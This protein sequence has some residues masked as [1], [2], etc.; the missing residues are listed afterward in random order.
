MPDDPTTTYDEALRALAS[1]IPGMI[2][3]RVL[4]PDGKITIPFATGTLFRRLGLA[5]RGVADYFSAL[6]SLLHPADWK[7]LQRS[8]KQSARTLAPFTEE[9]RYVTPDGETIWLKTDS[10]P[11][12]RDD[13]CIVWNVASVDVTERKHAEEAL[14][15]NE[16]RFKDFAEAA[17]DWLW[18]QDADLRTTKVYTPER[19][20]PLLDYYRV[21]GKTRWEAADADPDNDVA[22]R[23]HR[24]D[25]LARRPFRNFRYTIT[26]PAG[27]TLYLRS[28]GNPIFDHEG[29]FAGYRGGSTDETA[30]V[31][32]RQ[33]AERAEQLATRLREAMGG[34][35]QGFVIY[36]ADDRVVSYDE[37]YR[38]MF[39]EDIPQIEAGARFIDLMRSRLKR[40][41][42]T[43]AVGREEE[44]LAE[45]LRVHRTSRGP[46]EVPYGDGRTMLVV[47]NQLSDGGVSSLLIDITALKRADQE[48]RERDER[49]RG[50]T[51]NLPGF[52]LQTFAPTD[53]EHHRVIYASSGI[54]ELCGIEAS[55][56]M[57]D[58]D[59]YLNLIHPDD[60]P[61]RDAAL[62]RAAEQM[63]PYSMDMRLN[64]LNQGVR[65]VRAVAR[66]RMI[67]GVGVVWDGVV[68]DITALKEAEAHRDYLA[69]HDQ[70]TGLPNEAHYVERLVR[71][72][73]RAE[74]DG[75]RLVVICAEL[76]SLGQVRAGSGL[77]VADDLIRQTATRL[78][79]MVFAGDTVAHVGGGRFYV[80]MNDAGQD[81]E[82]VLS[83]RHMVEAFD[84]PLMVDGTS[85]HVKIVLGVSLYPGD[86][87]KADALMRNASTALDRAK[88]SR[89][90]DYQFYSSDMTERAM[91]QQ[92][93]EGA[94][95]AAIEQRA[96]EL[97]YQPVVR[98]ADHMIVGCEALLRW[99]DA[100]R[101]MISPSDFIPLAEQ[102]GLIVPLGLSVLRAACEQIQAWRRKG[103]CRFPVNVNVSGVQLADADFAEQVLSTVAESGLVP[104][105][106]KLELTESS[107][108]RNTGVIASNIRS[109]AQAGF[110]FALDDFGVEYSTFS[111]L[112]E[113]PIDVLKIDQS[114]IRRMTVRTADALLVQ[115]II[116]MTH[117]LG[118][119]AIAEGV[120]LAAELDM[121]RDYGCDGL[122]GN[123]FSR[124]LP[125]A[126]FELAL[127]AR[128]LPPT[129]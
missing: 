105:D 110:G 1:S 10:T 18:E 26:T 85:I 38:S 76:P 36:D 9:L 118:M 43:E 94:L 101:G 111:R 2:Y 107:V 128:T 53:G 27:E 63:A 124:A 83:V 113:L 80:L 92:S 67:G 104:S 40:G 8:L 6:R 3:T 84:L 116:S 34:L 103:L 56:F 88:A 78:Q 97:H 45:A 39:P 102:T 119:K 96:F 89:R 59:L 13:G 21:I 32:A 99:H 72:V 121:L 11:Y 5:S 33:R 114:F 14:R 19:P 77:R 57:R 79:S 7:R 86:S 25:L 66:P 16:Q 55:D 91:A 109:L 74:H 62:Q 129:P 22:W 49:I 41:R 126:E 125:V 123:L 4:S 35:R 15:E 68:L 82:V 98:P 12:R 87:D 95:R 122:Q 64:T 23:R 42:F 69:Q 93:M 58:P 44:W 127:R 100:T 30:E 115:A 75:E 28:S 47:K 65:W 46:Y 54:R 73:Q 50:I 60:R 29:R 24:E 51:D 17:S 112:T 37:G 106:L 71:A 20:S 61:L 52:I 90:R 108:L 48:I 81:A 117:V 31:R 70:L 120:E